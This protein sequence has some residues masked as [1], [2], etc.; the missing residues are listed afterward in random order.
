[1][2]RELPRRGSSTARMAAP[3]AIRAAGS[4]VGKTAQIRDQHRVLWS[5]QRLATLG[6]NP[7]LS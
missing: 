5:R 1:M 3:V 4:T 6:V 7:Y 2:K